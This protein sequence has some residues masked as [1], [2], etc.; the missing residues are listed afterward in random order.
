MTNEDKE[1]IITIRLENM[2]EMIWAEKAE[3]DDEVSFIDYG[4]NAD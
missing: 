4:R 3:I 2:G 1:T